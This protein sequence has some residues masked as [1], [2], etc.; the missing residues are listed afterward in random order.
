MLR[1]NLKEAQ[2]LYSDAEE[3]R[4]KLQ[5]EVDRIKTNGNIKVSE[6]AMLRYIERVKGINLDALENEIVTDKLKTMVDS[7][8]GSGKF[9]IDECT[10]VMNNHIIVTII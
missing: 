8:G 2:R 1:K 5:K 3:V 9:P 10:V 7:L 6:H 4:S